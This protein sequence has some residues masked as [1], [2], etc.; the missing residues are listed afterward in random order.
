[1]TKTAA[2]DFRDQK[3]VRAW[4]RDIAYDLKPP[5]DGAARGWLAGHGP[6]HSEPPAVQGT[7]ATGKA[8]RSLRCPATTR[9]TGAGGWAVQEGRCGLLV[10]IGHAVAVP[11]S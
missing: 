1:M 6:L 11:R 9:A 8:T 5:D 7:S 3:R 4:A 2:G 10:D